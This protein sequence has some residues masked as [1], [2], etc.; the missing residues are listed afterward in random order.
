MKSWNYLQWRYWYL[1]VSLLVIGTGLFIMARFG[2]RVSIDFTGGTLLEV[3]QVTQPLTV[4]E[5]A[6]Q[7]QAI[8]QEA[9]V[10]SVQ[11]S[12][13]QQYL[14]RLSELSNDTK[15][16]LVTALSP[17]LNQPLQVLR[18]ESVG[19]I[20]GRELLQKTLLAALLAAVFIT[21]YLTFQFKNW[22]FGVCAVIAMFHD[23]LILLSIF[24][25]LGWWRGVEIDILFV[26]AMMT[27]LSF[28]VHDTIVVFD[29]IRELRRSYS[30]LSLYDLAH[31]A[32]LQ[33]VSRS[34]NNSLTIIIMLLTLVWVGGDTIRWFAVALLVGA[35]TGTYSST[36]TAVPLLI[37]WDDIQTWRTKRQPATTIKS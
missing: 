16:A 1:A 19:P 17:D 12:G 29:R 8:D 7:L 34:I 31:I 30:R 14:L 13:D 32:V 11:Q 28:S 22:R 33:T 36:F 21:C 25:F 6:A 2:F 27:T 4:D 26:T 9:Q 37:V 23:T 35:V 18:F 24:A 3:A 5:V 15:D 20:L 10:A